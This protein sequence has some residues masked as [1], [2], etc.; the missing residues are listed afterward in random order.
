MRFLSKLFHKS[1]EAS[2]EFQ[3]PII[4][5][6]E[7]STSKGSGLFYT[8]PLQDFGGINLK[9]FCFHEHGNIDD[10][11][12]EVFL[13][14]RNDFHKAVQAAKAYLVEGAKSERHNLSGQNLRLYEIEIY[15]A[16]NNLDFVLG[17]VEPDETVIWRVQFKEQKPFDWGFDD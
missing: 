8:P 5:A 3:D 15:G 4:G 12:R 6:L 16:D 1:V 7:G 9:F 2:L 11:H 10:H 13:R 17:F 14:L